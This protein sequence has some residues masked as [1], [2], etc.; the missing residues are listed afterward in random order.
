MVNG[1]SYHADGCKCWAFLT[2]WQA[3][4]PMVR[5]GCWVC[6]SDMDARC[7]PPMVRCKCWAGL[8]DW[9]IYKCWRRWRPTWRLG[10]QPPWKRVGSVELPM[11]RRI[12]RYHQVIEIVEAMMMMIQLWWWSSD[13]P[14]SMMIQ[15]W[16]NVDD[17][18]DLIQR[19]IL[20][21]MNC[22]KRI[23]T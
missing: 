21:L 1:V 2:W 3:G 15:W 5:C 13:D 10:L 20:V 12:E 4:P 18:P 22:V 9:V 19:R 14:V 17:D 6:L 11:T 23:P 8:S 16:S 7:V